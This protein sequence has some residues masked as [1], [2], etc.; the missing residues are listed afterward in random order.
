MREFPKRIGRWLSVG[1]FWPLVLLALPNC[2]LGMSGLPNPNHFN[3]GSGDLSTGVMCDIPV[4]PADGVLFPC[5]TPEEITTLM[6]QG[7]AALAFNLG[8]ANTNFTLD[9]SSVSDEQCGAGVP[10][11]VQMVDQFPRGTPVCLNCGQMMPVPYQDT[12]AVCVAKCKEAVGVGGPQPPDL[13]AYC[14]ANARVSTN[15]N[16]NQCHQGI[17]TT[18]G[19]PQNFPDERPTSEKLEWTDAI[20]VVVTGNSLTFNGPTTGV[21]SAGAASVQLITKGD[22]WIEFSP[23]DTGVSHVLGLRTSSCDK[24]VNCPDGDPTLDDIEFG[25]SL[26]VNDDVNVV[27]KK[28]NIVAGPF[29]KYVKDRLFRIYVVDNHNGTAHLKYVWLSASCMDGAACPDNFIYEHPIGTGAISYPLRVDATFRESVATLNNV[30]I[31]RIIE[32][33]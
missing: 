28:G 6:P 10:R 15:F 21:F 5:A 20:G 29:P 18:G 33:W 24:V 31:M 23:G 17:C 32:S 25:L 3:P 9:Y 19:T 13:D 16:P 14:E 1:W 4:V 26:N 12:K 22:A 11:K 7:H 8:E 27:D 30:K 2:V